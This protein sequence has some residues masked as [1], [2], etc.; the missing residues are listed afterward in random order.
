MA[1]VVVLG[2]GISGHTAVMVL[3]KKLGK[4][5]EVIMVSP[6][7]NYQWVP[8]NIW[9]GIG[10]MKPKQV[11]F[12][13]APVYKRKGVTFKQAIAKTIFPEGDGSTAS[14]FVEVEYV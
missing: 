1:K 4:K 13:L 9:V 12:P 5:H 14:P 2:A 6:N 10:Q 8:S 7:S 11:I 3:R